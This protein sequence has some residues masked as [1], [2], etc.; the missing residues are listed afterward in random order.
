MAAMHAVFAR[1]V[2]PSRRSQSV[3]H[4]LTSRQ[5]VSEP[6]QHLS[7]FTARLRDFTSGTT[8]LFVRWS[9]TV[10]S[11]PASPEREHQGEPAGQQRAS[12]EWRQTVHKTPRQAHA[13]RPQLQ[14]SPLY[15]SNDVVTHA[16]QD[17]ET[18]AM[19]L[20]SM[21]TDRTFRFC[22][23]A[24]FQTSSTSRRRKLVARANILVPLTRAHSMRLCRQ[25][26][27]GRAIHSVSRPSLST[28][29]TN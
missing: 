24:S 18:T 21:R 28:S 16:I 25:R 26:E 13:C 23:A 29:P 5:P 15:R 22:W 6:L 7:T 19:F 11:G 27:F 4:D 17:L 10:H 14:Q 8:V 1:E 3:W 9:T 2:L 20:T 12:G